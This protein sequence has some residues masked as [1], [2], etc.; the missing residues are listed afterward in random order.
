MVTVTKYDDDITDNDNNII[1][2]LM[3]TMMMMMMMIMMMMTM[4]ITM[5]MISRTFLYH[6]FCL[7]L[8]NVLILYPKKCLAFKCLKGSSPYDRYNPPDFWWF[9]YAVLVAFHLS[10]SSH[11]WLRYSPNRLTVVP[12]TQNPCSFQASDSSSSFPPLSIVL[13]S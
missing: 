6:S 1:M 3:I 2:M 7:M 5:M 10:L 9:R 8:L 11:T 4:T 13:T 12:F